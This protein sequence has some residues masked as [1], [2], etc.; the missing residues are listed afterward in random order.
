MSYIAIV[1]QD[2]SHILGTEKSKYLPPQVG[3]IL[4]QSNGPLREVLSNMQII[5]GNPDLAIEPLRKIV[6]ELREHAD[7]IAKVNHR[8]IGVV[9]SFDAAL[10]AISTAEKQMEHIR[11]GGQ[12]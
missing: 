10:K 5:S 11:T 12:P 3:L 1:G 4:H 7:E 2:W 8:Y 9:K 6:G